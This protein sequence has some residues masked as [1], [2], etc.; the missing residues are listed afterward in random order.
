MKTSRNPST[1]VLGRSMSTSQLTTTREEHLPPIIK[2]NNS[3][4]NTPKHNLKSPQKSEERLQ[5]HRRTNS[6]VNF[7]SKYSNRDTADIV[8]VL[9]IRSGSDLSNLLLPGRQTSN[10]SPTGI[11]LGPGYYNTA[12]STLS[13]PS[14]QFSTCSRFSNRDLYLFLP[15]VTRSLEDENFKKEK[16]K[17][18]IADNKNMQKYV[19]ENRLKTLREKAVVESTK[20]V[21]HIQKKNEILVRKKYEKTMNFESKQRRFEYKI[22]KEEIFKIFKAWVLVDTICGWSFAIHRKFVFRKDL[23]LRSQAVLLR[24][25]V[26]CIACGKFKRL[27]RKIKIRRAKRTFNRIQA[28]ALHWINQKKSNYRTQIVDLCEKAISKEVMFNLMASFVRKTVYLQRT[29]RAVMISRHNSLTI[30]RL[31]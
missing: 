15:T 8:K 26:L 27:L 6:E 19:P 5:D 4:Y 31:L 22:K 23:H 28:P 18:I 24:L 25:L 16:A 2:I 11:K 21:N 9:H 17:E 3:N 20:I 30:K 1:S 10:V 7:D 12:I 13:G 29:M 14:F